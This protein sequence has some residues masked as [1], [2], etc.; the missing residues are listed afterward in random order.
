MPGDIAKQFLD[1]AVAQQM[2]AGVTGDGD[3]TYPLDQDQFRDLVE[4]RMDQRRM[5]QL[6]KEAPGGSFIELLRQRG[7]IRGV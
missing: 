4:R 6:L 3:V 5:Q 2:I 1:Q 7:L